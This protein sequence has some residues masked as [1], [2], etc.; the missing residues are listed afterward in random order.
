MASDRRRFLALLGLGGAAV[1]SKAIP[2]AHR[3]ADPTPVGVEP[4]VPMFHGMPAGMTFC[5]TSPASMIHVGSFDK[6]NL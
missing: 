6:A 3:F 1:A 2:G 4:S 5:G